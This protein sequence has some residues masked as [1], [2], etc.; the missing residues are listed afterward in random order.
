MYKIKEKRMNL[1]F[2]G[3]PCIVIYSYNESQQDAQFLTF[4]W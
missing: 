4:I 2:R 1:T 3:P